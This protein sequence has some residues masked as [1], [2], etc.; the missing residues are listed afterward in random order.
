[1]ARAGACVAAAQGVQRSDVAVPDER[2]VVRAQQADVD[3]IEQ[4]CAAITA[5]QTEHRIDIVIGKS[6]MQVG[7]AHAVRPGEIGPLLEA[8]RVQARL[9]PEAR[10]Q[11]LDERQAL[12]IHWAGRRN[13]AHQRTLAQYAPRPQRLIRRRRRR[14]GPHGAGSSQRAIRRSI[15][16]PNAGMRQVVAQCGLG[17]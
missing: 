8:A 14:P 17:A 9:Q 16:A 10:E 4:A 12:C 5:A 2:F 7:Q 6:R 3:A 11:R 13:D 15:A 1:M